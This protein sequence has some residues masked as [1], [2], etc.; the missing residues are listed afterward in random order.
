MYYITKSEIEAATEKA[1][2][3]FG[4]G[5]HCAEAVVCAVLEALGD[6]PRQAT[7]HATAFG[8]GMGRS[9]QEACG[10]L[11][12]GM[13]ALGHIHGRTTPGGNWDVPARIAADLRSRFLE[14]FGAVRC[15]AL[16]QRFGKENEMDECRKVVAGTV[17]ALLELLAEEDDAAE[18]SEGALKVEV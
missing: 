9:F 1:S 12:G 7:A 15:A 8:G 18:V 14:T 13:I 6:D 16:L 4:N 17:K 10:A 5:F 2:N 11:S 3:V